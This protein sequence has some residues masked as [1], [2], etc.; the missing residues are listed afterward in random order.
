MVRQF[1]HAQAGRLREIRILEI[2]NDESQRLDH[3]DGVRPLQYP[4][5]VLIALAEGHRLLEQFQLL[6]VV[7]L[8]VGKR[9]DPDQRAQ[10]QF[11]FRRIL[12][13]AQKVEK[14]LRDAGV[15]PL[16]QRRQAELTLGR[17]GICDHSFDDGD[18]GEA[19]DASDRRQ[20]CFTG[21]VIY[22]LELL[23][24]QSGS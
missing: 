1:D 22:R 13:L 4:A 11:P 21:R 5:T 16:R 24:K 2:G 15:W 3:A 19:P 14:P 10:Q 17:V 18:S 20:Q 7:E 9:R 8:I 6:L 12:G 23:Q